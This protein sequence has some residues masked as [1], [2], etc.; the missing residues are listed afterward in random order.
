MA[1][2]IPVHGPRNVC[3]CRPSDG[4]D[5]AFV[6]EQPF[7]LNHFP[8]SPADGAVR[9]A[10]AV[11]PGGGR[12]RD[13]AGGA[14]AQEA[15]HGGGRQ[16][17]LDGGLGHRHQ[18]AFRG[19]LDAAAGAAGLESLFH[20]SNG[21]SFCWDTDP[22]NPAA[23]PAALCT[24]FCPPLS[25]LLTTQ[26]IDWP[27]FGASYV[28]STCPSQASQ[29][30]MCG[31]SPGQ[32]PPINHQLQIPGTW[33]MRIWNLT[34]STKG[35]NMSRHGLLLSGMFPACRCRLSTMTPGK[36]GEALGRNESPTSKLA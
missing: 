8:I 19:Q 13:A 33:N 4:T 32:Q 26:P 6:P 36:P 27:D 12:Q 22:I 24:F 20:S 31:P 11:R 1:H 2:G 34:G 16:G 21:L 15:A 17:H 35:S 10:A 18:P 28:S 9:A 3:C 5:R 7:L 30:K 25:S 23:L 29:A 14:G